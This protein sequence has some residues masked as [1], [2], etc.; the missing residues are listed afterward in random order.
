MQRAHAQ[1]W[2]LLMPFTL[3]TAKLCT[4]FDVPTICW[5]REKANYSFTFVRLRSLGLHPVLRYYWFSFKYNV[6]FYDYVFDN[7]VDIVGFQ[8]GSGLGVGYNVNIAW[9]GGL[10]PPLGDAEYMAAFRTIVMPIAKVCLNIQI[11]LIS[12][13]LF[14]L[15]TAQPRE[16]QSNILFAYS[17]HACLTS[18]SKLF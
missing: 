9:S 15:V 17:L 7:N 6:F 8:C 13:W 14:N 5:I 1:R 16:N 11:F 10:N 3:C 12:Y 2:M 4:P 18:G